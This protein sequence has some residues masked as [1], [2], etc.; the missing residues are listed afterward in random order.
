MIFKNKALLLLSLCCIN[1]EAFMSGSPSLQKPISKLDA[2]MPDPS[3]FDFKNE[4]NKEKAGEFISQFKDT[5]ANAGDSDMLANLKDNLAVG[6]AGSRGE[7]Y[8][9]GQAAL[10]LCIALGGVPF[11][12]DA[13]SFIFGPVLFL[14]GLFATTVGV[15]DLGSNLSPWP[16]TTEDSSLVTE[17]IY[18]KLRHPI[19]AGLLYAC[20]G[21][22]MWSGSA[23]RL[24]LSYGLYLVLEQ[25]IQ[26]EEDALL[27]KF[28][29]YEDYMMKV[30]GKLLPEDLLQNLPWN[31]EEQ[32]FE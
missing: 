26:F 9:F 19:Y 31:S 10:V 17:G 32:V 15:M 14:A 11:F 24:I 18:E 2:T 29:G 6:N 5:L 30:E 16:A 23:M 21:M 12:G 28:D 7:A 4:F 8:F 20:V 25:K 1:V 27:E 13:I 22:S 3:N